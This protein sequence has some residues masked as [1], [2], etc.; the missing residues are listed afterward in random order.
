M[1]RRAGS[2]SCKSARSSASFLMRIKG[3]VIEASSVRGTPRA[4]TAAKDSV[5]HVSN[6]LALEPAKW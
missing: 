2:P 3:A 6:G 1:M 5:C 4:Y